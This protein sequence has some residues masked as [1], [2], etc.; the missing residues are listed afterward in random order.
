MDYKMPTLSEKKGYLAD[1]SVKHRQNINFPRRE[2][3]R[4]PESMS[5][6]RTTPVFDQEI[7]CRKTSEL[8]NNSD[9]RICSFD[10]LVNKDCISVNHEPIFITFFA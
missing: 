1:Q 6:D 7:N 4:G 2:R 9:I 3:L 8:C 5:D 10:G